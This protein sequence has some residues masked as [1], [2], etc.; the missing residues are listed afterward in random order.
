MNNTIVVITTSGQEYSLPGTAWT[1]EQIVNTYAA[2]VPGIGS[3]ASEVET[4][5][6]GD[7]VVTFRPRT[8][9]KG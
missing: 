8:G 5:A 2:S 4:N 6:N 7:K 1:P 9:S 3:M